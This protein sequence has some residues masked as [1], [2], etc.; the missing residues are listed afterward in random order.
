MTTAA[1][2]IIRRYEAGATILAYA[3]QGLSIEQAEARP[4]PGVWSLAELFAHM[5]DADLVG[6]DRMKRVIAE[7]GPTLLAYD[8]NAWIA[9]LGGQQTPIEDSIALFG[10][11]RRWM[12]AI[13]RRCDDADFRRAGNH[14]ER[15]RETLAELLAGYV[16]HLDHHLR[17]IYGKRANLGVSLFPR[18][19]REPE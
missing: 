8:E 9:R 6:A 18:Y 16:G 14:T 15:G 7:D 17:F 13:L 3:G 12:A 5:A 10:A 4:G 19:A 1:E 2:E 11:S